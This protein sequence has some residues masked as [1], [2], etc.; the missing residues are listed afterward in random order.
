MGYREDACAAVVQ[1]L[2]AIGIQFFI[3]IPDT[4][5][6]PV[7][8][9][10]EQQPGV[11]TFPVAREEEAIGIASGLAMTG[12]K[13]VLFCQDVG[14]GN[15]MV[16]LTTF[17]MAYHVP[18]LVLAIRRGGFGEFNAAVHTYSETAPDMVEAMRLKAFTL[19]YKVPLDQW[20]RAIQQAYDYAHMTHRPIIVF[21]NIKE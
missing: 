7:I 18:M 6:A 13:G 17:A 2:E 19:D 15:S 9:H 14:L 20:P 3:H 4:F 16:A 10:F 12:K 5:G 8:T 1:G 21:L 11:R